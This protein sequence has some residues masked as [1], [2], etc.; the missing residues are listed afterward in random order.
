MKTILDTI[1]LQTHQFEGLN[2]DKIS[3]KPG[4]RQNILPIYSVIKFGV[5]IAVVDC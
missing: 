1:I 2:L 4:D 3:G 5:I